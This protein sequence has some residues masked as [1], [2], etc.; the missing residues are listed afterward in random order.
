MYPALVPRYVDGA[1]RLGKALEKLVGANYEPVA[2]LATQV[3]AG[4]N[5]CLLCKISPVV[6]NPV[7]HYTLVYVYEDLE[8][9]AEITQTIDLDVGALCTYGA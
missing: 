3:V 2:N 9:G 7:P 8:G 1:H 4:Q 5:R 6:P